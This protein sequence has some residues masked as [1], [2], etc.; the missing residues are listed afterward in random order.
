[1]KKNYSLKRSFLLI[2]A[3]I[4]CLMGTAG[5]AKASTIDDI[6]DIIDTVK[7]VIPTLPVS[8]Q[9]LKNSA[10]LFECIGTAGDDAA[11]AAC[12]DKFLDTPVGAKAFTNSGLPSWFKDLIKLYIEIRTEN[13]MGLLKDFGEAIICALAQSVTGGW[14]VCGLLSGLEDIGGIMV[15]GLS[16]L[17]NEVADFFGFGDESWEEKTGC[18][19]PDPAGIGYD[20]SQMLDVH[21]YTFNGTCTTRRCPTD[22][23]ECFDTTQNRYDVFSQYNVVTRKATEKL[24]VLLPYDRGLMTVSSTRTCQTD[25]WLAAVPQCS[26]VSWDVGDVRFEKRYQNLVFP[27]TNSF[28]AVR[29]AE[30]QTK[31]DQL[32]SKVITIQNPKPNESFSP[33][34]F[35]LQ[36][37]AFAHKIEVAIEP[38]CGKN[39]V[40][41]LCSTQLIPLKIQ[42]GAISKT[43]GLSGGQY[44]LRARV[45]DPANV[46]SDSTWTD[47]IPFEIVQKPV[48][49]TAPAVVD[50][51][52]AT[53]KGVVTPNDLP[54]EYWFQFGKTKDYDNRERS[55][56]AQGKAPVNV[57]RLVDTVK[58]GE[59]Y[60]YR[61]VASNKAGTAYGD[62]VT[63]T[64]EKLKPP[65]V[66]VDEATNVSFQTATL[67][68]T[69]NPHY[70]KTLWYFEWRKA[71]GKSEWSERESVDGEYDWKQSHDIK[72]LE[73][74]T[75]YTFRMWGEN[76]SA[77]DVKSAEKTFRTKALPPPGVVTGNVKSIDKTSAVVTGTVNPKGTKPSCLFRYGT[78]KGNYTDTVSG[79]GIIDETKDSDLFGN[80]N[81]LNPNSMYYYALECKNDKSTVRGDEKSFTTSSSPQV[82]TTGEAREM[83]IAGARLGGDITT[84]GLDTTWWFEYGATTSYGRTAP[85]TEKEYNHTGSGRAGGDTVSDVAFGLSPNTTYHYRLVTNSS[86]GRIAGGDKT[87]T[88]R[89]KP[90]PPVVTTDAATNVTDVSAVLNGTVDAPT[91]SYYFQYGPTDSYGSQSGSPQYPSP[92][93]LNVSYTIAGG[94]TPGTTYHYR[95]IGGGSEN[96][97][98]SG[99]DMTF[100]TAQKPS[101]TAVALPADIT[102][103]DTFII[104]NKSVLISTTSINLDAKDA[105]QVANG[106]CAFTMQYGARNTGGTATGRFKS[107]WSNTAVAG[108]VDRMWDSI[109]PGASSTQSDTLQ[110]KPGKNILYLNFDP[111]NEIKEQNENNNTYTLLV[112]LAGVCSAT[113]PPAP[114]IRATPVAPASPAG[115]AAPIRRR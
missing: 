87:F 48:V 88:T 62:D 31:L 63:F 57:S 114:A 13:I 110:L 34:E 91:T 75:L 74:D 68:G 84:N 101:R 22:G 17:Y 12:V 28:L 36:G 104:G 103:T 54:T 67:N 60:H 7:I 94:L 21:T 4:L 35:A 52:S 6:A 42:N 111:A 49:Y 65:T 10:D 109:V 26:Q 76:S 105:A 56:W 41:G 92:A 18:L 32:L 20:F 73:P 97:V 77:G 16:D 33:A 100:T 11:A 82:V 14:D 66:S 89:D 83:T 25:P 113:P 107:S 79:Q 46:M 80:L 112:E 51:R 108:T 115:P 72:E 85:S 102:R 23:R 1:M 90:K 86:A 106:T 93:S 19:E 50:I 3:I 98:G 99:R 58:P 61:L 95:I 38:L 55:D 9:D 40:I 64:L 30:I 69:I 2:A 96:L 29:R 24:S 8:G 45:T 15:E 59:T 44:R 81:R 70:V 43:V 37:T 39:Y 53:L 78:T 71:D 5:V 27:Y 47:W